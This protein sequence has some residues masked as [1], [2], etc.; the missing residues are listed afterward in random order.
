M[1][2]ENDWL[3]DL[4][5]HQ[6]ISSSSTDKLYKLDAKRG[7]YI[8][9]I[10]LSKELI[11]KKQRVLRNDASGVYQEALAQVRKGHAYSLF[12]STFNPVTASTIYVISKRV[13]KAAEKEMRGQL[14]EI[15]VRDKIFDNSLAMMIAVIDTEWDTLTIYYNGITAPSVLTLS[16]LEKKSGD[17]N[18]MDLFKT[19]KGGNAAIF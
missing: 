13:A 7:S 9:D 17:A 10:L 3:V 8:D 18:I 15:K 4:M 14:S 2:V 11:K 12:S 6:P 1:P 5:T 16:T 19:L